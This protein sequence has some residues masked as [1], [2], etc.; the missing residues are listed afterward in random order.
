M[1][2]YRATD[3]INDEELLGALVMAIELL[4]RDMLSDWED[5]PDA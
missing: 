1:W 3:G 4:K 5:E 2:T